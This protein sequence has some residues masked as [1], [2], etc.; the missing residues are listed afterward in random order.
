M[1]NGLWV[2]RKKQDADGVEFW[3]MIAPKH[4]TRSRGSVFGLE[5]SLPSLKPAHP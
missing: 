1:E 4:S 5:K 2:W 3:M